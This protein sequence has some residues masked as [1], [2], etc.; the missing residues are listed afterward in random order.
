M[1]AEALW[2]RTAAT[3]GSLPVSHGEVES[4]RQVD[5][6][7]YLKAY[8]PTEL[9][10]CGN[11][12]Y[13]TQ[14]HDSLKIS[15]GKWFWW[16]RGIGGRSAL[17]Y[18]IKVREMAFPDA[19]R[20]ITGCPVV[21]TRPEKKPES[22]RGQIRLPPYTFSGGT[23]RKYLSSR[24][25]D[26]EITNDFIARHKIA[27]D[28]KNGYALFF[29]LDGEG[30][31]KQCSVRATDGSGLKKDAYG[32]DKHFAFGNAANRPNTTLRVFEA[33]IDLLSYTTLLKEKGI[34]YRGENMLSLS[35]VF[36]PPADLAGTKVPMSLQ[37]FLNEHPEIRRICLHLDRDDA[38]RRGAD[39]LRAVLG[40]RYEVS[41]LPPPRG[42]DYNDYLQLRKKERA[43]EG[44]E[45]G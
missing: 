23:V 24:A 29:G 17:D 35:G 31:V 21:I 1:E 38:G 7:S 32:S 5:L 2:E 18:L 19:V 26:E 42:K 8:E 10:P 11:G 13:C 20:A 39:G 44:G 33:A 43:L 41:Y 3:R 6:Y 12:V 45:R 37:A 15:N 34:D 30:K 4:A 27:E 28:R 40:E 25:I 22:E 36:L 9:V 16:S 14:S